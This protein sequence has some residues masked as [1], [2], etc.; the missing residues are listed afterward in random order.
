M[1][2][3]KETLQ[4]IAEEYLKGW[5]DNGEEAELIFY[6]AG[7]DEDELSQSLRSFAAL[8]DRNPL[9]A[10]VDIPNQEVFQSEATDVDEAAVREFIEGYLKRTITGKPLKG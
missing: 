5:K 3:A 4:P 6:N 2:I 9:L 10:I 1:K 7:N 8:S